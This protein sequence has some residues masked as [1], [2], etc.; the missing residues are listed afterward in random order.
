[1]N[2]F[3]RPPI[4]EMVQEAFRGQ[5]QIAPLGLRPDLADYNA[6]RTFLSTI[7]AGFGEAADLEGLGGEHFGDRRNGMLFELEASHLR[8]GKTFSEQTK[9]KSI[10]KLSNCHPDTI[11][12]WIEDIDLNWPVQLCPSVKQQARRIMDLAALR[13]FFEH[14]SDLDTDTRIAAARGQD[15][16]HTNIRL[17]RMLD[18]LNADLGRKG[19]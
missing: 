19:S 17:R 15:L 16:A 8:G 13:R 18:N 9:A 3:P 5:A 11:L 14:M 12:V 4:A 6:E 1:M 10:S 2:K 7:R